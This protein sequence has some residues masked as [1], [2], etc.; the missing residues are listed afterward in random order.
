MRRVRLLLASLLVV[1]VFVVT[2]C[3]PSAAE[4]RAEQ[5][6]QAKDTAL[7]LRQQLAQA[8]SGPDAENLRQ[9]L[10]K[11]LTDAGLTLESIH[12]TPDEL[13][14]YVKAATPAAAPAPAPQKGKAAR[15]PK[16]KRGKR[17]K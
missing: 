17:Q 9:Q 8:K 2:G 16:G 7:K 1:F 4:K 3:G 5:V 12:F 13:N 6:S 15:Q 14:N 10:V 11:G